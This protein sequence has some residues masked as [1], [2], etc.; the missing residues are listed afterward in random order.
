MGTYVQADQGEQAAPL[1]A[2]TKLAGQSLSTRRLKLVM[3]AIACCLPLQPI[4][5][6]SAISENSG[7]WLRMYGPAAFHDGFGAVTEV[8][9]M[10]PAY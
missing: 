4:T 7:V 8:A 6:G 1:P 9:H 3:R 10:Y 2:P 5:R